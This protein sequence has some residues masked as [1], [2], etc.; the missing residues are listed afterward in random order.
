M[1]DIADEI[2]W[3]TATKQPPRKSRAIVSVAF[4]AYDFERLSRHVM[5]LGIPLSEFIRTAVLASIRTDEVA[6]VASVAARTYYA[7]PPE[8]V[9][10]AG[11]T[12]TT[13]HPPATIEDRK[14]A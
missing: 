12:T 10:P 2:D 1:D 4:S 13:A 6:R 7:P 14:T 8:V 9:M 11:D 3:A 5:R